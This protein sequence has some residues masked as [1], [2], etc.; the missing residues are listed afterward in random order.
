MH[1]EIFVHYD[2]FAGLK[3]AYDGGVQRVHR[4]GFAGK[5]YVAF[6]VAQA[7]RLK[8]Q[9]VAHRDKLIVR[10]DDKRVGADK[11][12]ASAFNALF[13]AVFAVKID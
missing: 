2:D 8:T 5:K 4:A 7:Q 6:F 13:Q 10:H 12:L 9:R 3:V 11:L 1:L